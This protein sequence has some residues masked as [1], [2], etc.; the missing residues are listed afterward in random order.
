MIG[1]KASHDDIKAQIV[2]IGGGGDGLAAAVAAADVSSCGWSC[3]VSCSGWWNP[4]LECSKPT[5][6]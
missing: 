1:D 5:A 6:P 3:L 4:E 2:V